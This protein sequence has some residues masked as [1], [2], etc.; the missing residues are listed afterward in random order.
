MNFIQ[1]EKAASHINIKIWNKLTPKKN[2]KQVLFG[3]QNYTKY[4]IILS[5]NKFIADKITSLKRNK[6]QYFT[7]SIGCLLKF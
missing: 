5:T 6:Y 7:L 1:S 3:N 2:G 4:K